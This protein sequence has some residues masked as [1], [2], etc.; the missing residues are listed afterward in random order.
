MKRNILILFISFLPWLAT[1]Q[2]DTMRLSDSQYDS[3][4]SLRRMTFEIT[5]V[6]GISDTLLTLDGAHFRPKKLSPWFRNYLSRLHMIDYW[7]ITYDS[8]AVHKTF[9]D[10]LDGYVGLYNEYY[11]DGKLKCSGWYCSEKPGRRKGLWTWYNPDGTVEHQT[12]Y[13]KRKDCD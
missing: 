2:I 12:Q 6:N 10:H 8:G 13:G 9:T 7:I 1:A 3:A 5:T 11:P 4:Y